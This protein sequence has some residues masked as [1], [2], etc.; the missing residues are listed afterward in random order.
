M[1]SWILN[2][3]WLSVIIFSLM[4]A[5]F[6]AGFE[7]ISGDYLGLVFSASL[8]CAILPVRHNAW[9]VSYTHLTLPTKRIV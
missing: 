4:I 5:F 1:I 2:R 6:S 8:L 9:P 3:N 7:L